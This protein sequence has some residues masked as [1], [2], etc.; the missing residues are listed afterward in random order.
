MLIRILFA[1]SVISAVCIA[2]S[3]CAAETGGAPALV[4]AETTCEYAVNPVGIDVLRPRFTWV[5]DAGRRGTMQQAYRV[6]VAG[7]PE[8]LAAD[9]GDLWDSGKVT[10]D[11]SVNIAYNGKILS[12]RQQCYWKVQVWDDRGHASPWSKPAN[13]EM[14]LLEQSEWR[15]RWIGLGGGKTEFVS[16]LLRKKFSVAGP[17]K[18][19]TLYAAGIGWSEYYLNGKRIGDAVLDPAT[20]DY[21]K[22][23]LYVTHDVTKM[24]KTGDNALGAMLGNGWYCAPP[25]DKG[26]ADSPRLLLELVVE[27]ADGKAQRLSS[28]ETWRATAGPILKNDMWGGE[29]YDARLEKTGWLDATYDDSS[30]DSAAE[31]P[32]PGGRLEAQMI[33]PIRVNKTL[34]ARKMTNPKP[35]VYVYD[36]GQFFGGW[37]KL[38]VKGPAGTKVTL[39]YADTLA[40]DTGLVDKQAHYQMYKKDG[41]T[42]YYVLKGDPAGETYE[43]RFTFHP[44]QYVQIEGLPTAPAITDL[45][46]RVVYSDVNMAGDFECSN[47]LLNQIHRNCVWTFQN[48]MYGIELDCLFREHWGWLVTSS[49]ASTLFSRKHIPLFWT[50][51]L[52][53]AKNAQYADGHIPDV[54]PNYPRKKRFTGDPAFAGNYPLVA[55]FVYQTYG[56]RRILEEHYFSM[57][58]WVNYLTTLAKDNLIMEGGYYNDHMVPGEK[59]GQEK[60]LSTETSAPML[61]SGYY[62]LGSW[63][64]SQ[65]AKI[66]GHEADAA[67]YGKL[68]DDIRA[69]M[70]KKWLRAADHCYANDTLT[71]NIFS[72]AMGLVP[73]ENRQNIL[74]HLV[75]QITKKGR[76]HLMM[77]DIGV[78]CC[79]D[80]L[81]ALGRP[82]VLYNA[83]N[84][85]EFP[86]W[87]YMVKQGGTTIWESWSGNVRLT[88]S[89]GK[90]HINSYCEFSM[91]M[92]TSVEKLFQNTLAGI[93]GPRYFGAHLM[94]PGFREIRIRPQV[95][96][97]LTY[98]NAHILT[99]RGMV[100]VDWKRNER[101]ITVKATIPVNA[102][103]KISIPK[104]GLHDVLVE[105]NGKPVW[106]KG[107]YVG[108]AEGITAGN[109][110][111][112]DVTFDT[113]SG[114]FIFTLKGSDK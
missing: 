16:P 23:V 21:D 106:R 102:R 4:V 56:D 109:D 76:G 75:D 86:G 44:V 14:G 72:L 91:P 5:L 65:T 108:G 32:H 62:Y 22:R 42:D 78:T 87:G 19:A 51:F 112:D 34:K 90:G 53:D 97:D 101:G 113:G 3:P 41:A 25:P 81:A 88:G 63:I 12:S 103:A 6:L 40:P 92:F 95:L 70:N 49:D 27:T 11:E 59:P 58:R 35:N 46:G 1:L 38:K 73:E 57:K 55:W 15:G 68:A 28:D 104:L 77:G 82:D 8:K 96:G 60:F 31:K 9:A 2:A 66:L 89:F 114:T 43:P 74:D 100:A 10:S 36:F 24:L 110:E 20:T 39:K 111:R 17:V 54:V 79:M 98:A 84:T 105:E 52:D 18:R 93:D 50:K 80:A 85:V 26:Y 64:V 33:E 61:W 67:T 45:E 47:E 83:V 69:A 107:A 7:S 71:C 30:W 37:A 99:V 48:E 94:T 29:S 13:F